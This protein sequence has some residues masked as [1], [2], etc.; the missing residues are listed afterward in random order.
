MYFTKEE[1][2]GTYIKNPTE[3]RMKGIEQK[4]KILIQEK[5]P[6]KLDNKQIVQIISAKEVCLFLLSLC[7][8]YQSL[9][10]FAINKEILVIIYFLN[11][12]ITSKVKLLL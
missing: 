11:V 8:F 10:L 1:C 3:N 2:I 5:M 7:H 4:K 6:E 9:Y 12:S